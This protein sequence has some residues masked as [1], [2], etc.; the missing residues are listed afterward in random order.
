[1]NAKNQSDNQQLLCDN[2]YGGN[3]ANYVTN[4]RNDAD[5]TWRIS[6]AGSE[7]VNQNGNVRNIYREWEREAKLITLKLM[8]KNKAPT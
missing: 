7:R 5:K 6:L 2:S 4:N 1:M 3:D 8:G